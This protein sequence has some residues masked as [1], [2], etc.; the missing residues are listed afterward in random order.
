MDTLYSVV[1]PVK[2]EEENIAPL[3]AEVDHVLSSITSSFEIIVIDDGSTDK[4]RSILEELK[5]K[6]P[7]LKTIYFKQNYGQ[8]SAFDAGSKA[9]AGQFVITLDGD[10]QNDPHDIPKMLPLLEKAD[11]VC[12][13]RKE[14]K[15]P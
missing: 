6:Y 14:R 7:P 4:T 5:K 3:I 2:D 8:T 11:L 13:W 10:G 1:I 12:G 15:D 9:A